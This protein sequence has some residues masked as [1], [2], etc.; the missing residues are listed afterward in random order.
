MCRATEQPA[1]SV[2]QEYIILKHQRNYILIISPLNVIFCILFVL[3]CLANTFLTHCFIFDVL[4][5]RKKLN[6]GVI[7][8]VH[9]NLS[10]ALLLALL[11][12][13]VGIEQAAFNAVSLW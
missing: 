4:S 5:F 12:F 10:L 9:M 2:C 1:F 11:V 6:K 13:V 3:H 7:L 8:Y